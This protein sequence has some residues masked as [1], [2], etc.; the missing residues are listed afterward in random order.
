MGQFETAKTIKAVVE[1]M[2]DNQLLIP[3]FQ[4]NYVWSHDQVENLF[5]SIMRGYPI[6]SMLFWKVK[7]E[8]KT[9]YQYYE[10]L[11][12][13]VERYRT[14]NVPLEGCET[15]E[16][17]LAVLDGQQRLT[18]LYLG[19][20]GTFAYHT[21]YQ[22]WD[23]DS[24]NFPPR[25]LYL[26]LSHVKGSEGKGN[27]DEEKMFQFVFLTSQETDGFAPL[28][29]KEDGKWYLVGHILQV[30]SLVSFS[31]N[32]N[33]TDFEADVLGLLYEQIL[34]NPTICYYEE[35]TVSADQAVNIFIRINAGGTYLSM[36]EILMSILKAGWTRDARKDVES[37]VD[38]VAK[39]DFYI[40][41]D[42]IIKALLYL[43]SDNIKNLIQNF[44]NS[45]LKTT[46]QNWEKISDCI[47]NLFDLLHRFGLNHSTLLSYNA[48][49]PILYYMYHFTDYKKLV[50][51]IKYESERDDIRKW[52]LKT[53]LLKSF[54]SNSDSILSNARKPMK[55]KGNISNFPHEEISLSIEQPSIILQEQ[56]D[57]FLN[58]QK[59]DRRAFL[60][61]TLL[62]PYYKDIELEQDHMH[63]ICDY[64]EYKKNA[65][66]A[67]ME[68]W[69]YNSIVNLQFLPKSKNGSKN[70]T[71]LIDWVKDYS[72]K[73]GYNLYDYAYIPRKVNLSLNNF[74][75]FYI[76]RKK[77]LSTKLNELLSTNKKSE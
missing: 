8:A 60:I 66:E 11:R 62:F 69:Q 72:K 64:N 24:K 54:G 19:L 74:N 32:E 53:L 29:I 41:N 51:S 46:E 65:G 16:S 68:Y 23:N 2:R 15:R 39:L 48:T 59:D 33:L 45:F 36:S 4:R 52:L 18:S 12:S 44:N 76:E 70:H 21:K 9:S 77:L 35:D 38:K 1:M 28:V 57:D 49:L 17:F 5:D 67:A 55:D 27:Y 30:G 58:V 13:Y 42:Y 25:K 7:G 71:P 14:H 3:A 26:N 20:C 31:R 50:T 43:E 47:L 75:K 40:G 63:P 37:L 34:K 10:F 73:C 61:L 6:N 56:L 22:S